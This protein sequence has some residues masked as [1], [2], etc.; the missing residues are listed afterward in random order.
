MFGEA[1]VISNPG[2]AE[3]FRYMI[4]QRGGMLAKGWLL[5]LQ[6][7]VMFEDGLYYQAASRANAMAD[8]IRQTLTDLGYPLVVD[9]TTNQVFTTM[10]DEILNQLSRDFMFTEW[11]RVDA[12][13]RTIR[14]CTSWATTQESVDALCKALTKLSK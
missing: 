7:E 5:G 6:F 14:F 9:C 12:T 8:Q 13:H 11:T 4:K 3:D 2:I 10:P 1:V